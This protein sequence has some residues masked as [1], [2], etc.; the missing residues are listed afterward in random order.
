MM[1]EIALL[2]RSIMD[3]IV[4][5]SSQIEVPDEHAAEGRTY[6]TSLEIGSGMGQVPPIGSIYADR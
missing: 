1:D 2:T 6:A 5:I 4:E 3:I